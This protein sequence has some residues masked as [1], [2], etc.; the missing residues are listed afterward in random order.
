LQRATAL[1]TE[2]RRVRQPQDEL[3]ADEAFEAGA[4]H[5]GVQLLVQ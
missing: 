4:A 3:S 2:N 5:E 1:R